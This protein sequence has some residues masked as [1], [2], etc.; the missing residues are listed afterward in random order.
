M[1]MIAHHS[2]RIQEP[3]LLIKPTDL[4]DFALWKTYRKNNELP[5]AQRKLN[6]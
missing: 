2:V 3:I 6:G 1:Y 4:P 5:E